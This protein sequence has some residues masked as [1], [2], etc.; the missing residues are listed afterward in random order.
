MIQPSKTDI[1]GP[2]VSTDDP[3]GLSGE[4]IAHIENFQKQRIHLNVRIHE[5][6]FNQS[7]QFLPEFPG[8]IPVLHICDPPFHGLFERSRN[9]AFKDFPHGI[10]KLGPTLIH[11]QFHA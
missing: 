10:G 7:G 3:N 2:A 6:I 5:L 1:V 9:L 11:R 4:I 8:Q